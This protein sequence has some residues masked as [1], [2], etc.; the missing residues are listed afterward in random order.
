[1]KIK[2]LKVIV[3]VILIFINIYLTNANISCING[4]C[5]VGCCVDRDSFQHNKYPKETCLENG[6]SFSEEICKN[7]PTCKT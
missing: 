6:G 2:G 1:M 5:E 7:M 4:N 3:I